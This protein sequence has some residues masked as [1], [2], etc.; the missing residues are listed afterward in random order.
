MQEHGVGA[1]DDWRRL[2][3][4]ANTTQTRRTGVPAVVDLQMIIG[5]LRM[6]LHVDLVE[7]LH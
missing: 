7:N 3:G 1:G 2:F 6:S 5:A 4:A